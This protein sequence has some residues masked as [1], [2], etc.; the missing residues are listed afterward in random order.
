[1]KKGIV[2]ALML[3]GLMTATAL[4]G[5]NGGPKVPE[6]FNGTAISFYATYVNQ[7]SRN[8]YNELIDT[9]NNGQG[10]TDNVYV[11]MTANS[12]GVSNLDSMLT[13]K[14]R[15][16]VVSVANTQFKSLAMLKGKGDGVFLPLDDYLTD[17]VK[18]AMAWDE[19]SSSQINVWRFNN[20]K[21]AADSDIGAKNLAGT[22][23]E[24]LAIPFNSTAQVLFYN[25]EIFTSMG[26]NLVSVEEEKC[27]TGNYQKLLPHGYAEYLEAP[28][29]GAKQSKNEAGEDVYK[30][31]NN[32]VPMN[33]EE[34]RLL[35]RSYQN[36]SVR[37]NGGYGYMS[38]WWFNYGWSVGGDCI[39]WDYTSKS[40]K[41][42]VGDETKNL[43]ALGD[44]TVNGTAY[45]QGEVLDYEDMH[46]LRDHEAELEKV[47][48]DVTELP[49]MYEAFLEFNR[50]GI[51][52]T[53]LAADG[54]YGYGVAKP[55]TS[56]R[57]REFTA[58]E[59]PM[60]CEVAEN[61]N[62]YNE[63]KIAGKFDIAPLAQ[64]REYAGGSTRTEG[65]K[66]YLNVVGKN[67]WTGELR[68][69]E[70]SK[71]EQV[72]V[73]GEAISAISKNASA[74]AIPRNIDESKYEA[75]FK[76]ISWAC[77]PQGQEI[78]AKGNYSTPNQASVGMSDTFNNSEVR[79]VKNQWAAS[80]A[81]HNSF[82]GDWS[83]FNQNTWITGWSGKLNGDVREGK[84]TLTQ[85][86]KDYTATATNAISTIQIRIKGK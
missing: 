55:T 17:S 5:C 69:V 27:G 79:V 22:G 78:L 40:Y 19:I 82:V 4:A 2:P 20:T 81:L 83:Y 31:F 73:C 50:L 49:S 52:E 12:G 60:L 68:T 57:D 43:L 25:T 76:F 71:G 85:F 18:E 32:R 56:N 14:T 65:G 80:F 16:D 58:G 21:S 48:K 39:G 13:Q 64:Y 30:V 41:F 51:P 53:A 11:E 35:A 86:V 72:A 54:I 62:S 33:W 6:G 44:I 75:A 37:K 15:Y 42:A 9:Y 47:S 45:T 66:E 74:L 77:G 24:L 67:G 23:A 38:E 84:M 10:K 1:M 59:S 28:F 61:I 7:Y 29:A 46:W 70:N 36:S 3:A 34:V 26:I 8:A 63:S